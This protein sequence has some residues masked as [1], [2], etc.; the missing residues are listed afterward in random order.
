MA[1]ISYRKKLL[2]PLTISKLRSAS[3]LHCELKGLEFHQVPKQRH[4]Q[5]ANGRVGKSLILAEK[6]TREFAT[7][8]IFI[9][10]AGK[11]SRVPKLTSSTKEQICLRSQPK[12]PYPMITPGRV[13][14]AKDHPTIDCHF[15]HAEH[16]ACQS[17]LQYPI[18]WVC[19]RRIRPPFQLVLR[20]VSAR[21]WPTPQ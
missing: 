9:P 12:S 19:N 15:E 21:Q 8:S 11:M 14:H 20:L 17:S 16:L 2:Q 18:F 5:V 7:L 13:P 1:W 10:I 6:I 3:S 4:L